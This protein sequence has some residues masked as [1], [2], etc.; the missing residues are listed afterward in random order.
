MGKRQDSREKRRKVQ[1]R[2]RMIWIGIIAAFAVVVAVLLIVPGLQASAQ[3]VV[4]T[5]VALPQENGTA[6]GNPNAP[7][8]VEVFSDFLCIH[9]QEYVEGIPGVI[10]EP[11]F[12]Q[13]YVATDKVYYVYHPF[14]VIAPE[15]DNG[16][17]AAL[18]AADQNKFWQYHNIIFANVGKISD[19]MGAKTLTDFARAAG[20][21]I[22]DFQSCISS[23]KYA[24]K[25]QQEQQYT[26]DKGVT[27]TPSFL[28]NGTQIVSIDQLQSAVDQALA[29]GSTAPS[30]TAAPAA[31]PNSLSASRTSGN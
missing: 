24:Q 6:L 11:Q 1:Q 14:R 13:Q 2:Q 27:G 8:K 7:V 25:I 20:L 10:S 17:E 18:C 31:T 3:V 15:S 12:I 30:S 19:P 4:P 26:V 21:N 29:S 5:P 16:A 9:C 22:S 28:I 23:N